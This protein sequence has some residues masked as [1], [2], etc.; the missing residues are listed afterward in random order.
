MK[1]ENCLSL[2]QIKKTKITNFFKAKN[3]T[4]V[5]ISI[6]LLRTFLPSDAL[7]LVALSMAIASLTDPV[8]GWDIL[9]VGSLLEIPPIRIG[10]SDGSN[11]PVESSVESGSGVMAENVWFF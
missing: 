5:K 4:P 9:L 7:R 8:T 2:M 3:N 1:F 11:P 6:E 10:M